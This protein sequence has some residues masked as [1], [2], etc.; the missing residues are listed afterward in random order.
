MA[1]VTL[2]EIASAG[3][4]LDRWRS[5]MACWRNQVVTCLGDELYDLLVAEA[6]KEKRSLSSMIRW[7]LM[8]YFGLRQ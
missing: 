1:A 6:S 4:Y 7:I 3:L 8:R 2:V 5:F